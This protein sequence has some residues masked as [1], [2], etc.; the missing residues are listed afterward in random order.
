MSNNIQNS[1]I[2]IIYVLVNSQPNIQ[3]VEFKRTQE[4]E[5]EK[6]LKKYRRIMNAMKK[7]R[8]KRAFAL[9]LE[10]LKD[11]LMHPLLISDTN[12]ETEY[13]NALNNRLT[14]NETRLM[15]R[16]LNHMMIYCYL[17]DE[18]KIKK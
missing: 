15:K 13:K 6:I 5:A 16:E 11:H 14:S 3:P 4:E 17:R 18:L 9:S 12:S 1:S 2:C 8:T 7:E 10:K